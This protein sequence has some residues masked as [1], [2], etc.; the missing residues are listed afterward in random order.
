MVPG[1]GE[2]GAHL[3]IRALG[4]GH[5]DGPALVWSQ[6]HL[7]GV[8]TGTGCAGP[9]LPA[10]IFTASVTPAVLFDIRRPNLF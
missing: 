6:G 5:G 4:S 3:G 10:D 7:A 9:G 1:P 8:F 2:R